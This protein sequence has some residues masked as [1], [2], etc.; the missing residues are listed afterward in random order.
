M[1]NSLHREVPRPDSITEAM[2]H[3]QTGNYDDCP[4]KDLQVAE[5]VRCRYSHPINE[6]KQLTPVVELGKAERS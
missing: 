5:R 2:E 4:L 6:K 3:S 1:C